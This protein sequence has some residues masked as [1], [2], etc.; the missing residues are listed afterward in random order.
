MKTYLTTCLAGFTALLLALPA[1]QAGQS[2][3][4]SQVPAAVLSAFRAAYPNA[5]EARYEQEAENGSTTYEV[6]FRL[7]GQKMEA[8][9]SAD[10]KILKIERDD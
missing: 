7:D 5:A 9:Y 10:G 8:E 6:E 4:E 1:V 3:N 2:L